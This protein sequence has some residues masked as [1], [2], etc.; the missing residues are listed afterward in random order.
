MIFLH[1]FFD[2]LLFP[3]E[4]YVGR[5]YGHKSVYSPNK[6]DLDAATVKIPP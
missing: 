1:T 2:E 3:E 5:D 6:M 4:D